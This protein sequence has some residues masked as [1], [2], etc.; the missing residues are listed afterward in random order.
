M[1]GDE[2]CDNGMT[3]GCK[4][5]NCKKADDGFTCTGGSLTGPSTC[6]GICGDGVKTGTEQC[7]NKNQLGCS[8]GCKYDKGYTCTGSTGQLS[9]CS[10]ICGDMMI[11]GVEKC[12]NGKKVGCLT[13]LNPDP[14]YTCK[15][16]N[17]F[18]TY[19]TCT[20]V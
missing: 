13:C 2:A 19:S 16:A 15:V 20:K 8:T 4:D 1:V 11:V 17:K 9:V 18:V 3:V 5:Y 10:P 12:D 7:D 14:G 6:R